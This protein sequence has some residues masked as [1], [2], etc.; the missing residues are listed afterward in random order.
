MYEIS[1]GKV[2]KLNNLSF[3]FFLEC[4]QRAR[5]SVKLLLCWHKLGICVWIIWLT[6]LS[7]RLFLLF[8]LHLKLPY[9]SFVCVVP[10]SSPNK[11]IFQW[12][13]EFTKK[14]VCLRTLAPKIG[15]DRRNFIKR[16][17]L[18]SNTYISLPFYQKL[19]D[20]MRPYAFYYP[21][22]PQGRKFFDIC[23]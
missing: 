14:C 12:S 8:Q 17:A 9:L 6:H 22:G 18:F 21:Q 16:S 7:F 19:K 5:N 2:N 15:D 3:F 20:F 23:H 1:N 11:P 4:R 10:F 13:I